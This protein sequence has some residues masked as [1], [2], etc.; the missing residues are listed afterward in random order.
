MKRDKVGSDGMRWD[1][2]ERGG[3][4][5]AAR[6]GA[7]VTHRGGP[8]TPTPR[9]PATI[10][11]LCGAEHGLTAAP[12]ETPT[13]PACQEILEAQ[14]RDP[15]EMARSFGLALTI[16]RRDPELERR[17]PAAR[18][19]RELAERIRARAER[20]RPRRRSEAAARRQGMKKGRAPGQ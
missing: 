20:Y 14:R 3:T 9:W 11:T 1:G 18:L 8:V 19:G 17:C 7:G 4:A 13:C 5:G 6:P 16:G 10:V 2:P 12:P 15:E